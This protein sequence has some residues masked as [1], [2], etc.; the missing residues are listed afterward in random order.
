VGS[1]KPCDTT[2][3]R[4]RRSKARSFMHFAALRAVWTCNHTRRCGS[5]ST[6]V[7]PC[8]EI[9]RNPI[10]S[11]NAGKYYCSITAVIQ[12][13]G[14]IA[15]RT[16]SYGTSWIRSMRRR[17]FASSMYCTVHLC[18][19]TGASAPP[20]GCIEWSV[21]VEDE[22]HGVFHISTHPFILCAAAVRIP[23]FYVSFIVPTHAS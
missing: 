5:T 3:K 6:R 10:D 17:G 4:A 2:P 16:L 13:G 8:P 22:M 23:F 1:P 7:P 11:Q 19:S 20:V 9:A 18:V 12:S 14:I 15:C 21:F